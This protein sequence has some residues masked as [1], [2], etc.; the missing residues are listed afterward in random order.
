MFSNKMV[1]CN[2]PRPATSKIPS[3]SVSL[4]R[5]ATLCCSS[6][7]KRSQIWRLVTYLPSRPAKGE[8]LTQKFMVK[9]G[10]SI[11]SMGKGLGFKGSVMVTPMPMSAMPLI[12][13]M[14]PGPASVAWIRS[15]PWNFNTWFTRPLAGVPSSPSMTTTS[16]PG[17]KVPA[18]MRPTPMRPTKVE[19]SK[20]DICNC[21]GAEG[22]PC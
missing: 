14:S 9:V 16:M 7:C 11:L 10:S 20:A 21:K 3:S 1:R 4:T 2:S 18:L 6:F 8:V 19:K 12:N 15:R 22:S 17:F 13:T 5:S